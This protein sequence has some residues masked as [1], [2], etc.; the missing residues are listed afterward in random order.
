MTIA[1]PPAAFRPAPARAGLLASP[2]D[3]AHLLAGLTLLMGMGNLLLL[4]FLGVSSPWLFALTGAGLAAVCI[5]LARLP[6][7]ARERWPTLATLLAC[8][9]VA[10]LLFALGGQ[11]RF[12][13]ANPD[14]QVREAVLADMIR[15][16][17]PFVYV[18]RGEMEVL[19]A[20]IGMYLAPALAGKL[21]GLRAADIAL[22]VQNALVLAPLL[23]LASMLL[24]TT[25]ARLAALAVVLAFSG[26]DV[27]GQALADP[28]RLWP[29]SG[30][31]DN[32]AGIQYSA[33]LTLAFW[34]PQ[35]ALVGWLGAMCFLLWR[36]GRL[37]L[38][39]FLAPLPLVALWS[40]L[41]LIGTM[42]FALHAGVSALLRRAIA[43]RDILLPAAALAASLAAL[44]YLKADAGDVGLRL[45]AIAP[46]TYAI[47]QALEVLPFLTAAWL[48]GGAR[49]H[50]RV[51]LAIVAAVLI[52]I[53]FVQ[54]GENVDL[55][56]RGS[57]P[58]LAILALIVAQLLQAPRAAPGTLRH[59]WRIVLIVALAIGAVTPAR[60]LLRAAAYRPAPPPG[61]SFFKSWD[62]S[63]ASFGKSTYLA[64][65]AALPGPLRPRAP[66]VLPP[67]E[68]AR[69]Y[70]RPWAEPRFRPARRAD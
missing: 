66:A 69:C 37:P 34:V 3:P 6:I 46:L 20:P 53:P 29:L 19:R 41:G 68:P 2:V 23:A 8:F 9:A 17:W 16:P 5:G 50:G 65:L 27:I 52:L 11:G 45:Y 55:M 28:S 56:M 47:F 60:E 22:L 70:D 54:I 25:R 15:A 43:P 30:H 49:L 64:E 62:I 4:P 1:H 33:T 51:T 13:Y 42:P 38:A 31:I 58:A 32:W 24:A 63:Y 7:A 26:M 12:F 39:G 35:H 18:A 44:A 48:L 67:A 40:P 10:I 61:C 57:I 59:R 14:W 36:A 21:W